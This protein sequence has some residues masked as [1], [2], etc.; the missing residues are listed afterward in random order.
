MVM[1]KI[2]GVSK[3]RSIYLNRKSCFN[4]IVKSLSDTDTVL[5]FMVGRFGSKPHW[6]IV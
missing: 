4:Q 1:Q 3:Q 6:D 5:G 2:T